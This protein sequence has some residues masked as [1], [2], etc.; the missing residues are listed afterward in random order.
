MG[1]LDRNAQAQE[2]LNKAKCRASMWAARLFLQG[3]IC[4]RDFIRRFEAASEAH[5]DD[6]AMPS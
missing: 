1:E 5:G 2:I 3:L 6:P 4:E